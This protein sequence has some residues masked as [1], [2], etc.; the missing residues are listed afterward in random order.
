MKKL[1]V[2]V[3][4]VTPCDRAGQVDEGGLR[5]VCRTMQESGCHA[6]FVG[7]S[8]SRGPWFSRD[9]KAGVC[10]TVAEAVGAKTPLF[11]GCMATG[12]PGMLENAKAM[13]DAGAQVA[14]VT[15]PAYFQYGPQEAEKIFLA[16]ADASPLPVLVYD[17]P[18]FA[19]AGL[20]EKMIARL[21]RHGNIVGFKDSSGELERFKL[22]LH[23]LAD[24]P[25]F[26][27]LQGKEHL[28]AD[29]LLAGASGL[30]CSLL[31]VDPVPFVALCDAAFA[32]QGNL[33]IE[34]QEK[35]SA[36]KA[37][38]SRS[39]HRRLES[40]TLFHFMNCALQRQG[41]CDNI[42]LEHEGETPDWLKKEVERAMDLCAE[43]R[44]ISEA[45]R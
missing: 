42:L 7:G 14:V 33:C 8:T 44:R 29:S 9:A 23:M 4:I 22:L 32:G 28:L 31:H 34:L 11:A 43:A 6:F 39:L 40:S 27:V 16:F 37:V 10:C 30:V 35:I 18:K 21:A 25:E 15:A 45:P 41:I 2:V 19:D 1:G 26:F 17:V 12:L 20:D 38:L 3:P 13:A 36:V 5:A 24:L